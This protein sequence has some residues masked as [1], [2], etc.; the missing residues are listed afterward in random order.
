MRPLFHQTSWK[1]RRLSG[2]GQKP[3]SDAI[4]KEL[5]K[6]IWRLQSDR[7]SHKKNVDEKSCLSAQH[8]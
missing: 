8:S 6:W 4:D 5:L 1:Q 2:A 7:Q 3:L